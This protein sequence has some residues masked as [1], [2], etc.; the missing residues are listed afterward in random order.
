MQRSSAVHQFVP[1][2]E[3]VMAPSKADPALYVATVY[4][5]PLTRHWATELWNRVG[6]LVGGGCI[7][8]QS[9]K[10]SDLVDL[11]FFAD[12]VQAAA[13]AGVVVVSVRDA[14]ALPI[15][16]HVWIDA[17][18]PETRRAAGCA[19]GPDRRAPA[20]GRSIRSCS[21]IPGHCRPPDRPGFSAP[22]AQAAGGVVRP[23]QRREDRPNSQYHDPLSRRNIQ[24]R[25]ES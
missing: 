6:P 22:R 14:G 9:W 21:R 13:K 20:A 23:L 4:Q 19:G 7:C 3:A 18:M 15:N 5:D 25:P 16:L 2:A 17:W 10:I 24:P 11:R 12:A 1:S 8:H